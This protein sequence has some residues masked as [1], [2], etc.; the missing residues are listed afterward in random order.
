MQ[1]AEIH[2]RGS[3][4]IEILLE[5]T[6]LRETY[7]GYLMVWGMFMSCTSTKHQ[8]NWVFTAENKVNHLYYLF[9]FALFRISLAWA[10]FTCC[11]GASV[12]TLNSYTKTVIEFRH[13][14]KT[15]E[16]TI[17]G[18]NTREAY[19]YFR[20]HSLH[21]ISE[22]VNV[23]SSQSLK[24]G[25]RT[26]IPAGSLDLSDFA[27]SL[28]EDQCWGGHDISPSGSS[29]NVGEAF[30]SWVFYTDLRSCEDTFSISTLP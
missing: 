9:L 21:S 30:D 15:F 14:R 7:I 18:E 2:L 20:D 8:I 28:G 17:R 19:G 22:T 3:T 1:Y 27:A 29:W 12:T 24:S 5:L 6:Y 10:S 4:I 26:P 16:Q 25:R 11:M 13:K 23:Y